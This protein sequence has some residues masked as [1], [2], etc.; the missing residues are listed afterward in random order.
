MVQLNR[1]KTLLLLTGAML[2]IQFVN[3]QVKIGG[4][5]YDGNCWNQ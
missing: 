3:A 4:T 1:L 5:V 2:T